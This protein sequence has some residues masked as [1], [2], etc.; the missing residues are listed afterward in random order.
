MTRLITIPFSHFCEKGRWAL[1]LARVPYREDA[2]PP[3][4][5]R[6]PLAR[7]RAT[8]A[9]VL[10]LGDGRVLRESTDIVRHADDA[11]GLGLFGATPAERAEIETLVDR[12]DR[13]LGPEVRL[14]VYARILDDPVAFTAL[15]EIGL[16][17]ARAAAMRRLRPA[18]ARAIRRYFRISPATRDRADA[19]VDQELAFAQERRAGGPYLVGDR[20]TAADL[21]FAALAAPLTYVSGYGLGLPPLATMPEAIRSEVARRRAA[22]ECRAIDELYARH[23]RPTAATAAAPAGAPA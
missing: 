6:L 5:H 15:G 7:R 13:V 8:T 23:R 9:P 16:T 12:F 21:T 3:G 22:P 4:V 10:V 14:G 18:I 19:L 11:A 17:G 20:F 2:W 1:D